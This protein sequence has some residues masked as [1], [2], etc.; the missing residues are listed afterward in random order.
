MPA[1]LVGEHLTALSQIERRLEEQE[2]AEAV[3]HSIVHL[4]R[5]GWSVNPDERARQEAFERFYRTQLVRLD[6]AEEVLRRAADWWAPRIGVS[7][8]EYI[9]AV[10]Q[11]MEDE[12]AACAECEG[13][14]PWGS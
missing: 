10:K 8:D 13:C 4:E 14:R 11:H 7:P 9:T 12:C 2:I 3:D 5:H 6:D 1:G